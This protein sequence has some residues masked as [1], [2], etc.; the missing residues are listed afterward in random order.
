LGWALNNPGV[1]RK[2]SKGIPQYHDE[3]NSDVFISYQVL[4]SFPLPR[5][6][7]PRLLLE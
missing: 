4:T 5:L 6:P 3:E 1:T 7:L 2:T